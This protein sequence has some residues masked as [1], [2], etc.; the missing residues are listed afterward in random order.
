MSRPNPL[1]TRG[2]RQGQGQAQGPA[3]RLGAV[4]AVPCW[5]PRGRGRWGQPCPQSMSL[6]AARPQGRARAEPPGRGPT[7]F[8]RVTRPRLPRRRA[9]CLAVLPELQVGCG[10]PGERVVRGSRRRRGECRPPTL[11]SAAWAPCLP[12]PASSP[13]PRGLL[14]C[15]LSPHPEV[16]GGPWEGGSAGALRAVGRQLSPAGCLQSRWGGGGG[17]VWQRCGAGGPPP[18]STPP[19]PPRSL[20]SSSSL[21]CGGFISPA[22]WAPYPAGVYRCHV[23]LLVQE[24]WLGSSVYRM[25]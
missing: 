17:Q 4:V 13:S 11:W 22:E 3:P 19:P 24:M 8:A 18:T 16:L 6:A 20:P 14:G 12:R 15:V 23:C 1:S 5:C 2:P 9:V 10:R 21:S 25:S 7:P